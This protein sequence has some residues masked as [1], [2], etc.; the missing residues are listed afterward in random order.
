MSSY[1]TPPSQTEQAG[2]PQTRHF[3]H[4]ALALAQALIRPF[5]V[6]NGWG[7]FFFGAVSFI[8]LLK[9]GLEIYRLL[10]EPFSFPNLEF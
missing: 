1:I 4:P 10:I 6:K 2:R 9:I 3:E 5:P 7:E 8:A